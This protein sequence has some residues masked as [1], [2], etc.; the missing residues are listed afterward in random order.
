MKAAIATDGNTVASH[1]GRCQVYT[2]LELQD[3]KWKIVKREAN[4]GH[5][6]GA[7]P[8]F[9]HGLEV[10]Q[11]VCGGI[12]NRAMELFSEMGI[13]VTAGIEGTIDMVIGQLAQGTLAGGEGQCIPGSGKGQGVEKSGC[14]HANHEEGR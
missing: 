1:F 10:E 13:R 3:G 6:P 4:P 9:L 14:D 2:I 8:Q 12:G 11:V 7:I 5:L